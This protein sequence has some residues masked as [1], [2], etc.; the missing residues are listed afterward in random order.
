MDGVRAREQSVRTSDYRLRHVCVVGDDVLKLSSALAVP[1]DLLV[2]NVCQC[3]VGVGGCSASTHLSVAARRTLGRRS[4]GDAV[5]G[6]TVEA[7]QLCA[8][9][10]V[11]LRIESRDEGRV[12][13]SQ[14]EI[15][16]QMGK[17]VCN[18]RSMHSSRDHA[19]IVHPKL[20]WFQA[21]LEEGAGFH[22]DSCINMSPSLHWTREAAAGREEGK[23]GRREEGEV[24]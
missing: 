24:N 14:I 9:P 4:V 18:L 11:F 7:E 21:R 3:H 8:D 19:C 6:C 12:R 16:D 10:R 17:S 13:G 2:G 5:P 15:R 22:E 23:K 20:T 1:T